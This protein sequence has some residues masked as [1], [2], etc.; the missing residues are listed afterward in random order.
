MEVLERITVP[1]GDYRIRKNSTD[2]HEL[3]VV[4]PLLQ[5]RTTE[6]ELP[7]VANLKI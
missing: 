5:V 4:A 2:K 1:H 3:E 6:E 7:E